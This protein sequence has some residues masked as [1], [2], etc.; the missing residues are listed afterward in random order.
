MGQT[1][2]ECK[3]G[4][5]DNFSHQGRVINALTCYF[6]VDSTVLITF[7]VQLGLSITI[8]LVMF[9]SCRQKSEEGIDCSVLED[10]NLS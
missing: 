1:L 9:V 10:L 4:S 5:I 3:V 2:E 8:L 6:D 7:Y